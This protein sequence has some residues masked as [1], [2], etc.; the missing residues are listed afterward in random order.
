MKKLLLA[1]F[2]SFSANADYNFPPTP[3]E[4]KVLMHIEYKYGG[5]GTHT[6]SDVRDCYVKHLNYEARGAEQY[7]RKITITRDGQVVWW[8]KYQ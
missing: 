3:P 4:P 6:C 5:G 1:L 2:V 8:R 7:C